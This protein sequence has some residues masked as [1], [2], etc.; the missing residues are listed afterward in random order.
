MLVLLSFQVQQYHRNYF[1]QVSTQYIV[2]K[3]VYIQ[4]LLK[5]PDSLYIPM[6]R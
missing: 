5:S 2:N 6:A 1:L 3:K 4:V